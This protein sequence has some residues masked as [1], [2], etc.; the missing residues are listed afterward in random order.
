[1]DVD[2]DPHADG[3]HPPTRNDPEAPALRE[4]RSRLPDQADEAGPVVL[5]DGE[6]GGQVLA[7]RAVERVAGCCRHRDSPLQIA[8]RALPG[9]PFTTESQ[10]TK[11]IKGRVSLGLFDS[12]VIKSFGNLCAPK[13]SNSIAL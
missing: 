12:V 2:G 4:S 5:G 11:K 8:V 3:V 13:R 1:D 10:S 7:A 6:P 9:E